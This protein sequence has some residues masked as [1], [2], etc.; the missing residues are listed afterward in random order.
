MGNIILKQNTSEFFIEK[1]KKFIHSFGRLNEKEA[2]EFIKENLDEEY[3]HVIKLEC[4]KESKVFGH[5]QTFE[6]WKLALKNK[7]KGTYVLGK[8]QPNNDDGKVRIKCIFQNL[9]TINDRDDYNYFILFAIY[10]ST[11]QLL[12]SCIYQEVTTHYLKEIKNLIK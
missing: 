7:W 9:I 8:V 4:G 3:Q 12:E 1:V 5:E 10:D 11:T 6:Y 2:L